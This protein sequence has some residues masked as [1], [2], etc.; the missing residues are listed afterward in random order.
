MWQWREAVVVAVA[1]AVAVVM[2]VAAAVADAAS[3][4]AAFWE[5]SLM[6]RGGWFP[7]PS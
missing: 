5:A 1:M 3:P 4:A 6:P 7:L 2:A